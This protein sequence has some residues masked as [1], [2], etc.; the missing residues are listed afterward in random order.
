MSILMTLLVLGGGLIQEG[1]G[2][3]WVMIGV[4]VSG[5]A[6]IFS[7]LYLGPNAGIEANDGH[8]TGEQLARFVELNKLEDRRVYIAT[9]SGIK[10]ARRLQ[11]VRLDGHHAIL[12]T[13]DSD[14]TQE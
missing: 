13:D 12:V 4:S 2:F 9:M 10:P 3:G 7:A 1:V 14:P 8:L 6:F 5:V 11:R